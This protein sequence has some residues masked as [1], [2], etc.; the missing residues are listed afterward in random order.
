MVYRFW[1]AAGW[2]GC[3]VTGALFVLA[4][5]LCSQPIW[6][7]HFLFPG[8]SYAQWQ[9]MLAEP[10][11]AGPALFVQNCVFLL[12]HFLLAELGLCLMIRLSWRE[13]PLKYGLSLVAAGLLLGCGLLYY[14]YQ[15]V[16]YKT[17]MLLSLPLALALVWPVYSLMVFCKKRACQNSQ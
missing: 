1:K 2:L 14:N 3:A 11:P 5:L 4:F 6:P 8:Y 10:H 17:H 12:D 16:W 15:T 7:E 13:L 9:A